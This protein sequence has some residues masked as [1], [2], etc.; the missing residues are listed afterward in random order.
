MAFPI[1]RIL[2]NSEIVFGIPWS[3]F[4]NI[5]SEN[6]LCAICLSDFGRI[7]VGRAYNFCFFS[8]FFR[9]FSVFDPRWTRGGP[10]VDPRR[11]C[12][13][14]AAN[15]RFVLRNLRN[16]LRILRFSPRIARETHFRGFR[17]A[18][19]SFR[20]CLA[21]KSAGWPLVVRGLAAGWPRVS[22][23][24]P[25]GGTRAGRLES[26]SILNGFRMERGGAFSEPN[27]SVAYFRF[28]VRSN[29]FN[30]KISR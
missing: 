1:F 25:A 7:Y 24:C 22:R 8:S 20:G 16:F 3:N 2:V 28:L 6:V 18:K 5:S 14:P 26:A 27:R 15:L 9:L 13:Q 10:A 21:G 12:G 29:H 17:P 4:Y 23:G 19:F 11:T 30:R